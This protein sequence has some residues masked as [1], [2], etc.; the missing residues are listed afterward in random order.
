MGDA[1]T[2]FLDTGKKSEDRESDNAARQQ[3]YQFINGKQL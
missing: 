1:L 2:V 3:K